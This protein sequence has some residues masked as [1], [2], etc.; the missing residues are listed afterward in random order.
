MRAENFKFL[1]GKLDTL[2]P[3]AILGRGYSITTKLPAG[4][5]LKD[6]GS[7][8]SGDMIETKLG[9]GK[10]KSRVEGVS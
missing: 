5:V 6:A 2:S 9:K 10:V 3:L 1:T 7:L 8:K 4:S